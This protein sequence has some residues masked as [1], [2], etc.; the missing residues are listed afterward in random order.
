MATSIGKLS[1]SFFVKVLVGIIILPFIFWGMGDVFRGGNQNIIATIDSKKVN[2]QEF[3]NYVKRLNLNDEQLKN[4]RN[5]NLME[6]ILSEFI[7]KK[8]MDLEIEEKGIL[9]SDNSLRNIIKSDK[10][11][12]KNNKFSRVEYEK[13]L[14]KSGVTAP[15]FEK[16]IIEQERKRQFLSLIASG[17]SIPDKL[18]EKAYKKENQVKKIEYIDLNNYHK[19]L[20]FSEKEFKKIYEEN[21]KFFAKE[22]KTIQLA[23]ISP[24]I[25]S[26]KQ[27]FDDAFFKQ[28]DVIENNILDGQTFDDT[29]KEN[30]L[31]IIK[32][33]D[34][35][36]N[37]KDKNGRLNNNISKE[38]FDKIFTL[39]SE[40]APEVLKIDQKFF[41]IEVDTVKKVNLSIDDKEVID[42]INSQLILKSKLDLN[43]SLSKDISL[44]AFD[45]SRLV[46]FANENN[47]NLEKYEINELK[48]NDVFSE[49]IVKRIFLMEDDQINLIT[50]SILSKN[51][52]VLSVQTDYK[53]IERNTNDFEKYDAKARLNLINKIYKIFDSNL[54]QKYEV[55]INNRTLERVKNSF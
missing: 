10:L 27:E 43:T 55:E 1:K 47:L 19:N 51:F 11:F 23:E 31:K 9:I 33:K 13:F 42:S 37:R 35:D 50:D 4:I 15:S 26:G 25:I 29:V 44:G 38:I 41:I 39:K 48:Q 5:S 52:L 53:K 21:K 12:F 16:N 14:L 24:Q 54:N 17:I 30:N 36:K 28:L 40:K 22:Y 49:G 8:V 18:I 32:I 7:G 6:R 46:K 3:V 45:K 34:V 2:T 20:K